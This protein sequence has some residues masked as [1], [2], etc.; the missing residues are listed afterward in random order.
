MYVCMY[1][2]ARTIGPRFIDANRVAN[3]NKFM[4]AMISCRWRYS[5]IDIAVGPRRSIETTE[6]QTVRNNSRGSE[7]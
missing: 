2:C 4:L 1:V 5:K 7:T 6:Q 3:G